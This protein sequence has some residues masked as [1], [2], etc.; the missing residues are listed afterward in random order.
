MPRMLY[1][2][3]WKKERTAVLVE[4]AVLGGFRGEGVWAERH[5]GAAQGPSA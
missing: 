4:Q 1:G 5:A 2:T 3:A